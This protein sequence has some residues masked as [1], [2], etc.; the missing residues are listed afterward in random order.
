VT[1]QQGEIEKLEKE[2]AALRVK[3]AQASDTLFATQK[4]VER[5]SIERRAKEFEIQRVVE[6]IARR[7][8]A[9]APEVPSAQ[10]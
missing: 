3:K 6:I 1:L 5:L 7:A 8:N 2:L 9:L 10:P 4:E